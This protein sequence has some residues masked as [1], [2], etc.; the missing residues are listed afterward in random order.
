MSLLA[1]AFWR[2]RTALNGV[3][4]VRCVGLRRGILTAATGFLGRV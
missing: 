2:K 3:Q 4:G 1:S